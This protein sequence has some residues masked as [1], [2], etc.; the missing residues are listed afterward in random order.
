MY[1]EH[2]T[3]PEGGVQ[4]PD[5]TGYRPSRSPLGVH[6]LLRKTATTSLAPASRGCDAGPLSPG[7]LVV[8]GHRTP[9]GCLAFGVPGRHPG[10]LPPSRRHQFGESE[11]RSRQVLGHPH[12]PRVS[13]DVPP[14]GEPSRPR[15]LPPPPPSEG[16]STPGRGYPP[17]PEKLEPPPPEALEV[18][19]T[20]AELPGTASTPVG[21]TPQPEKPAR[22]RREL[23]GDHVEVPIIEEKGELQDSQTRPRGYGQRGQELPA[24]A[25]PKSGKVPRMGTPQASVPWGRHAGRDKKHSR[26]RC[27]A[28][29]Y[30]V[31][32]SASC[33]TT[34]TLF[35]TR[36]RRRS[37][38]ADAFILGKRHQSVAPLL[39]HVKHHAAVPDVASDLHDS[40]LQMP[41]HASKYHVKS[42]DC[43]SSLFTWAGCFV[44]GGDVNSEREGTARQLISDNDGF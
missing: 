4:R 23:I 6:V 30:E 35:S 31:A 33:S 38:V 11:A 16:V 27:D 18:Q 43:P 25:R 34:V 3:N 44:L 28:G 2:N 41:P 5:T 15:C 32:V 8:P 21:D 29:N 36:R 1:T 24:A 39:G 17:Q 13:G 19:D 14:A 37:D 12:P 22:P 42:D 20:P 9:S 26:V 10:G 40:L 7:A